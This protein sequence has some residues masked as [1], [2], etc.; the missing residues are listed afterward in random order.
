MLSCFLIDHA[1]DIIDQDGI[2][3]EVVWFKHIAMH[4]QRQAMR[5]IDVHLIGS[6][7]AILCRGQF[8][9]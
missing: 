9:Q 7:I 5:Y 8:V 2:H 1:D 3:V 4:Y 6:L